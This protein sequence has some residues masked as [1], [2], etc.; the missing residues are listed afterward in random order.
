MTRFRRL[1][2]VEKLDARAALRA[3]EG[4]EMTLAQAVA[5]ALKQPGG[6]P[7]RVHPEVAVEE[8]LRAAI[9]RGCRPRT[10]QFYREQLEAWLTDCTAAHLDAVS[11]PQLRAYL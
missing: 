4:S 6:A 11:R 1:T 7:R 2:E 3:L 9:R 10:Q 8:F 5:I